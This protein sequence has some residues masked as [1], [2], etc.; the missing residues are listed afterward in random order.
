MTPE[1]ELIK[2]F[3][4]GFQNRDYQVMQE[5]Y[6]DNATFTDA[7]FE[8]LDA[9]EVRAMWEMLCK[10]G[11]DLTIDF[12]DITEDAEGFTVNWTANYTFSATG[13]KVENRVKAYFTIKDGKIISHYDDFDFYGWARQALGFKGLV[14]GW[15]SF[16]Q[17]K[18]KDTARRSLED[19]ISKKSAQ[20]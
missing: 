2:Q 6:A 10:R 7:V 18:V 16:V 1:T 14:L 12:E 11:K 20:N 13:N 3:Y 9:T 4:R 19:F 17:N 5:C 8:D 15:T